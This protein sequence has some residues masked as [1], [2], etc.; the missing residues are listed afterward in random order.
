MLDEIPV[1]ADRAFVFGRTANL[2][3]VERRHSSAAISSLKAL[4]EEQD[5]DDDVCAGI[6]PE[7]ALWQAD[8]ADEIR[9]RGDVVRALA[10]ALSIVPVE[11]TNAASPPGFRR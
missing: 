7:A 1:D 2:C 11:V 4:P 9:R 8:C 10:S 3:E 5:V 6:S